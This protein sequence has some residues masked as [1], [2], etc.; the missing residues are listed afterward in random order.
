MK[1]TFI[2]KISNGARD[3]YHKY[4]ILPSLVMAQ[5]ILESGWGRSELSVASNNLFGVKAGKD[6]LGDKVK[7][8]TKEYINN[9]WIDTEA[10]FRKYDT[11]D[12][13]ILDHAKFLNKLRY[14]SV[15]NEKDYKKACHNIYESGYATDPD[16]P[17]KL[18]RIIN[19]NKLFE[20]DTLESINKHWAENDYRELNESGLKIHDRRFNDTITRGEVISLFNR[21]FKLLKK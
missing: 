9:K 2:D 12:G 3:G 11:L 7:F 1:Q 15:I 17:E 6:W 21:L 16:Y 18:I 8:P 20:Y 4:G 13:S 5:A 14:S 19:E 10:Y